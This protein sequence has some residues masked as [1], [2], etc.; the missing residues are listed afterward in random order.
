MN[1]DN[2]DDVH[3]LS[4][5]SHEPR[6]KSDQRRKKQIWA[7]S[8]ANVAVLFINVALWV[9]FSVNGCLSH[10]D[11]AQNVRLPHSGLPLITQSDFAVTRP[12]ELTY[13]KIGLQML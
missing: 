11:E 6:K 13:T 12:V 8:L 10:G 5:G 9:A 3:S 2:L 7:F 4:Y 1:D